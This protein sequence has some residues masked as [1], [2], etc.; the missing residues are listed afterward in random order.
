MS[1]EV[2]DNL[3]HDNLLHES[4]FALVQEF[5]TRRAQYGAN[6]FGSATLQLNVQNGVCVSAEVS[7]SLRQTRGKHGTKKVKKVR[8]AP[9][10]N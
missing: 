4:I 1:S 6:W 8:A 5:K 2:P 9:V 7:S 3:Q 10:D